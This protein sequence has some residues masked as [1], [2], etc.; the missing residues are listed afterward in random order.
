[1]KFAPGACKTSKWKKNKEKC[2]GW[3]KKKYACFKICWQTADSGRRMED[4][5]RRTGDGGRWTGDGERRTDGI[6]FSVKTTF[7][8]IKSFNSYKSYPTEFVCATQNPEKMIG[9]KYF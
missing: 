8:S 7:L 9:T 1:M 3:E 5:G 2:L 4:G 6:F